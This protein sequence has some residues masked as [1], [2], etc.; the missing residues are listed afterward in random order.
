MTPYNERANRGYASAFIASA[1]LLNTQS[2]DFF[3]QLVLAAI[4]QLNRNNYPD[5]SLKAPLIIA[6]LVVV[7]EK[8]DWREW[9]E[10]TLMEDVESIEVVLQ[11]LW[12]SNDGMSVG[13]KT[14]LKK[15]TDEEWPIYKR[16]YIDTKRS[17]EVAGYEQ[18]IK[19]L[20]E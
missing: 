11:I 3:Q 16:R 10:Q 12:Y 2:F 13:N 20:L 18:L 7:H 17:R 5:G 4:D 8:K 15:R 6:E 9:Y 1:L 19:K 14:T